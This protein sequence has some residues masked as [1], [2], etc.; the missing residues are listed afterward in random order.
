MRLTLL[1]DSEQT[2]QDTH[3]LL[4]FTSTHCAGLPLCRPCKALPSSQQRLG[5]HTQPQIM[6][7]CMFNSSPYCPDAGL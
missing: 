3:L 7:A 1:G 2:E 5:Y 4:L 6:T